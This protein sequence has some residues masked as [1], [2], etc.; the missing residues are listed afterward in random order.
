MLT[1]D[2]DPDTP[3]TNLTAAAGGSKSNQIAPCAACPDNVQMEVDG[4]FTYDPSAGLHRH[5]HLQLH[6]HR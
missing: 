5:R 6:R 2:T 1:G 3:T 4:Q